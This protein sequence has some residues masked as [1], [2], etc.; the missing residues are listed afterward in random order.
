MQVCDTVTLISVLLQI[1]RIKKGH[2]IEKCKYS[3]L[4]PEVFV[5]NVRTAKKSIDA[6]I[7]KRQKSQGTRL[8]NNLSQAPAYLLLTYIQ[9]HRPCPN[10]VDS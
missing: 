3:I 5:F 10:F 9:Y 7:S 1:I 2:F 8:A 4:F 6:L